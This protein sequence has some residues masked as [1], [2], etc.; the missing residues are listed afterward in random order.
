MPVTGY[1]PQDVAVAH[2]KALLALIAAV[3]RA[4]ETDYDAAQWAQIVLALKARTV[5]DLL[6]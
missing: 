6:Q 2:R 5:V 1:A 3:D 4:D